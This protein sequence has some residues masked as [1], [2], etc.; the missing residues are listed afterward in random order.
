M[1]APT[2][3]RLRT[4]D[5]VV[6][7]GAG[8]AGLTTALSLAPR[9]VMLLAAAPLGS[10]A[11]TG[12]AQGGIAAAI[13]PDDTTELHLA[14]T[15]AAGDGLCDPEAAA[16]LL[17][18]AAAAIDR[19]RAWGCAFDSAP[20]GTLRLGLEAAHARRRIVHADGDGTG[21]AVLRALVARARR[22]PSIAIVEG[23][24]ARRL[25]LDDEGRVA[26]LLVSRGGR[27]VEAIAAADIV[28]ATGGL[29]G[30][31]AE[32][33][34]PLGAIG[35]GIALAGDAGA[36]VAAL[37]FV[38]FH[39]TAIDC[40]RDPMPLAS[41]ALRGEGVTLVD[42]TGRRFMTGGAAELSP[43]DVVARAIAAERACG[44][45]VFLDARAALGGRFAARF[46]GV[47]ALCADAGLDPAHDPIPVRPAAHYAMGGV[48]TDR[49]GQTSVEG[50]HASGEVAW[51]GLHGANRLASNSLLEA[52]VMGAR[53]ATAIAGATPRRPRRLPAL[54]T[55]PR[56]GSA[57]AIR[58][59]LS[60]GFGVLRDRAGM[61][62]AVRALLALE[63]APEVDA[64]ALAVALG[65]AAGALARTESRGGHA[66]R[67]FPH[68]AP[69][70]RVVPTTLAAAR[71][72]LLPLADDR[73][74]AGGA[75]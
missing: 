69:G 22:T 43:R 2:I 34:N 27:P 44:R 52:V 51:T 16:S 30:L 39:P 35:S 38:Q 57:A 75:P 48:V 62:A 40:G 10:G 9:P 18:E 53:V 19:L 1:S 46:P 15:L 6:V 17:T 4:R 37:E 31:F 5:P 45:R 71:R 64:G 73:R 42:E 13:G 11:A 65:I 55:V 41:E 70:S 29:G 68:P 74:L 58:P 24:V 28:L 67:D 54:R 50:L 21:A 25:L 61:E 20:D 66:R 47:H 12:W 32:T 36:C 63:G 8:L 49:D 60:R 72:A 7:V 3:R 14:D 26:G 23:V 59:I 33:T 56:A